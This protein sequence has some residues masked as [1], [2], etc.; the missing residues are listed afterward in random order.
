MLHVVHEAEYAVGCCAAPGVPFRITDT[1]E[2]S[3]S[4]YISF[5]ALLELILELKMVPSW[6]KNFSF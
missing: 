1:E 3:T 6:T 2:D 5:T 4:L